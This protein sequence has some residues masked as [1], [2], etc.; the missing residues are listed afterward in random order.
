VN[1]KIRGVRL[2]LWIDGDPM[3]PREG[4]EGTFEG[5]MIDRGGSV[6]L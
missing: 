4:I 6:E 5:A 1:V 2:P 3:V